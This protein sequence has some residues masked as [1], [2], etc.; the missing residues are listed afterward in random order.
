M[1]N[2]PSSLPR[3]QVDGCTYTP[4]DNQIRTE[5]RAGVP[6]ARRATTARP[7]DVAF[8]LVL[9]RAQVQTLDDFVGIT[10]A[11]VLP[12]QWMDF[13]RP[14]GPTNVAVYRFKRRPRYTPRPSG[15]RWVATLELEALSLPDGVFPLSNEDGLL[16]S[17]DE[18]E[19]V[20][21]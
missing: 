7:V 16:L 4:Q 9:N 18:D 19:V 10:L 15:M 17:T 6:K 13:R 11:D 20:T 8:Q 12:F 5:M 1:D 21:T 2:W 14:D 3:P